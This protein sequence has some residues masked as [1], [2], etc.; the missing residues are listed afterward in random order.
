MWPVDRL[1]ARFHETKESA[2]ASLLGFIPADVRRMTGGLVVDPPKFLDEVPQRT[3]IWFLRPNVSRKSGGS[4]DTKKVGSKP[5]EDLRKSSASRRHQISVERRW[6]ET[7][8][9][10]NGK[11]QGLGWTEKPQRLGL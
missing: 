8:Y 2:V 5:I 9:L 3:V 6:I 11:M 7:V 1:E 10:L 4:H